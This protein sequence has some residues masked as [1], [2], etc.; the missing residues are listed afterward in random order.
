MSCG[1]KKKNQ[2]TNN[3]SISENKTLNDSQQINLI[4]QEQIDLLVKKIKEINNNSEKS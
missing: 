2:P 4:D 3:V 1:C